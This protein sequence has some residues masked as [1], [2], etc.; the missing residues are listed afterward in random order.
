MN[1]PE[2]RIETRA[3]A[4]TVHVSG[5]WVLQ[6]ARR[7]EE[8]FAEI[9]LPKSEPSTSG[10]T[11]TIIGTHLSSIDTF[12]AM[13]LL[14][15]FSLGNPT[16]GSRQA[17]LEIRDCSP[18]NIEILQLAAN[19]LAT[20][21]PLRPKDNLDIFSKIGR[22]CYAIVKTIDEILCFV[23]E[24]AVASL[25]V[26]K[27]RRSFRLL[28]TVNQIQATGYDAVGIVCLVTFL[29]GV[30]VAYLTGI[31]MERYGANLFIVD[32]IA[33]G[34][35]REL[36]PILVAIVVAGRSGSAFTAQLGTMK[37]NQ[38]VDAI[39]TL[40]ISPIHVL[41]LPRVLAL[42]LVMPLLVFLGDIA[43]IFGGLV[44]A[45]LRL[46]VSGPT[47]LERLRIILP[48]RTVMVGLM[49]APVFAF[50]IAAIACHLGLT[51]EPN[52]RSVG[53][54]TTKTVVRA[55]VAVILL[56]AAFAVILSE[57]GI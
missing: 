54:H 23:G 33:L 31:Q 4:L 44:A 41:V 30:V 8:L 56:N 47:F 25:G 17:Q 43:G 13:L 24:I 35:T 40:G 27:S 28:E 52:A 9:R 16:Y 21:E 11:V 37:L 20:P 50:F 10:S 5:P 6:H 14:R 15:R 45:D 55:I 46:G 53:E 7:L 12:G 2:L 34:M 49:K 57:L 18:R 48:I 29:I 1:P 51:T 32:G 42:M 3:N 38:E 19:A 26:F 39:Q 22:E 36:A